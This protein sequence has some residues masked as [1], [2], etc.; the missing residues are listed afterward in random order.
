MKFTD[1]LKLI[2]IRF[3]IIS[4]SASVDLIQKS[5][6]KKFDKSVY[7]SLMRYKSDLRELYI[8]KSMLK[9]GIK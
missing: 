6:N 5:L 8:R 4:K 9:G 2:W 1:K 7:T 3:R